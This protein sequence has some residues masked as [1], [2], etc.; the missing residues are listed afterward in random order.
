MCVKLFL[1][2]MFELLAYSD[3][4]MQIII[5]RKP[6]K[7]FQNTHCMTESNRH[8]NTH[9]NLTMASCSVSKCEKCEWRSAVALTKARSWGPAER[10]H[11]LATEQYKS[12]CVFYVCS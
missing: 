8:S 9:S 2:L 3:E 7:H 12:H 10:P 4:Y 1:T 6:V 5:Q 11:T